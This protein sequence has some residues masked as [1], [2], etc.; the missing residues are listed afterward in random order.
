MVARIVAAVLVMILAG[1]F[2]VTFLWNAPPNPVKAVV[3][4]DVVTYMD[5]VF[6]QNWSLFAP[7]PVNAESELLV[8]ADAL[9]PET[10]EYETTQW[11]SPTRRE[12]TLVEGNP[13]PPRSSRLSANV[14]R[15]LSSAWY[16]LNVEQR[17][18]V[19]RDFFNVGEDWSRLARA[20]ERADDD[21]VGQ[22]DIDDMVLADQVATAYATQVAKVRWGDDLT[23]VQFQIRRTPVPR[24]NERFD[25]FDPDEAFVRRFGWRPLV[26]FDGQDDGTFAAYVESLGHS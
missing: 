26:T 18:V 4:P 22:D 23:S 16:D 15:R 3:R 25:D 20:L 13:F 14:Y 19:A 9:N 2:L 7:N 5:P 1:H 21:E 12:W 8:R 11:F 10:G 24:W 6:W 17:D